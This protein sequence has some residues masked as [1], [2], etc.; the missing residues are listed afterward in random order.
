M[1]LTSNIRSNALLLFLAFLAF[2][3]KAQLRNGGFESNL[4]VPNALGQWYYSEYW[5]NAGSVLSGPDYY[6]Y[7]SNSI[8]DIPETAMGLVNAAQGQ[9]IMGL[10]LAGKSHTNTR[11]YI[12]TSFG[13]PLVV[14]EKYLVSFKITNGSKTTTSYAGL[15]VSDIG[16]LFSTSAPTQV[17]MTPIIA[18]PQFKI[19]TVFYDND[20]KTVSF[21]FDADQPYTQL[22][23]GV[24]AA[25]NQVTIAKKEGDDPYFAYYFVDDFDIVICPEDYD[26]TNADDTNPA[27]KAPPK[28]DTLLDGVAAPDPFFIPNTFSPDGDNLNDI[29]IPIS[30]S[31]TEWEFSI[32]NFWGE[33]LFITT[34]TGLGWDGKFKNENCTNGKYVWQLTYTIWDDKVGLKKIKKNGIVVLLR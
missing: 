1:I 18:D 29:F 26:P 23:F 4:V 20:W 30:N 15:G 16:V 2:A 14:G 8:A 7:S 11:E 6:T 9:S 27:E 17:D 21:V 31:L 32:F 34:N 10:I 3:G 24:F 22:T 28:D 25:D 13:S 33:Q 5:T 19:D 12:S